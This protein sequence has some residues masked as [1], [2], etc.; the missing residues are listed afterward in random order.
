MRMMALLVMAACLAGCPR[1][2]DHGGGG[3]STRLAASAQPDA[4]RYH[5]MVARAA[6]STSMLE[7]ALERGNQIGAL[8]ALTAA[9]NNLYGAEPFAGSA[10]REALTTAE[11]Q[12]VAVQALLA[13]GA[14]AR[15]AAA[16]LMHQLSTIQETY[17]VP[18]K[19]KAAA[20]VS[21][22]IP[23]TRTQVA[24]PLPVQA[25]KPAPRRVAPVV[26][27]TGKAAGV[28]NWSGTVPQPQFDPMLDS[29]TKVPVRP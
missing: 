27:P 6:A 2:D 23:K 22:P 4:N 9:R 25:P 8:R 20:V 26:H 15:P 16:E 10:D 13:D 18:T 7:D 3:G 1:Q 29:G 11:N 12:G 14:A 5:A 21:H 19:P 28:K 24:R 17:A